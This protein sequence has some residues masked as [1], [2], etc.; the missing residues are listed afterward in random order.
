VDLNIDK[1]ALNLEDQHLKKDITSSV[2]YVQVHAKVQDT[3][4]KNLDDDT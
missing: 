3:R 1:V 4:W 2:K